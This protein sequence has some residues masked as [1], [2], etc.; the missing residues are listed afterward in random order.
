M[1]DVVVIGA[2][3]NG[4]VAA[5]FLARAGLSVTVVEEK[6][7]V[8][9]ACKTERPFARAP[10]LPTSTGAYLLGLMPPEL[11]VKLGVDIPL[12]RRDPHYFLPTTG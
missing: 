11:M 2:G 7:T 3:H 1:P 10:D 8:G 9:G 12:V 6:S 4:L 5:T